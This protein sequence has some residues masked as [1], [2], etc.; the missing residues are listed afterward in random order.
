MTDNNL[1]TE[2]VGSTPVPAAPTDA[3]AQ[4]RSYLGTKRNLSE[5]ELKAPGAI[6]L[7]ISEIERLD[8]RCAKLEVYESKYHDLRVEKAGLESRLRTSRWHE[9]LTGLCLALGSAGIGI[10]LKLLG[11]SAT[12]ESATA[13]VLISTV[14]VIA[15][16]AAKVFK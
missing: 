3:K 5:Q 15:G 4:G 1:A 12:K 14:L 7:L 13:V 16:I 6:R 10:G 9:V 2:D 11:E 8:E